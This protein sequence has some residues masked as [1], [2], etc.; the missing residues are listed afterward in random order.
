MRKTGVNGWWNYQIIV[1]KATLKFFAIMRFTAHTGMFA[2]GLE[3]QSALYGAERD[4]V[5]EECERILA[6]VGQDPE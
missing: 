4:S 5:A 2:D 1:R 3:G 6:R